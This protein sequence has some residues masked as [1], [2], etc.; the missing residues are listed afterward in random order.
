[1]FLVGP[2][3]NLDYFR[4]GLR[5]HWRYYAGLAGFVLGVVGFAL[6][7]VGLSYSWLLGVAGIVISVVLLGA[8]LNGRRGGQVVI[9]EKDEFR[10]GNLDIGRGEIIRHPVLRR[11]RLVVDPEVDRSLLYTRAKFTWRRAPTPIPRD[12]GKYAYDILRHRARSKHTV[13][14]GR[15]VRQ[16]TDL[17]PD[18]LGSDGVIQLSRTDY[19]SLLC[20]NYMTEWT[21]CERSTGRKIVDGMSL[22]ADHS[23]RLRSLTDSR[24]ANVIGVST[25]GL[26]I[27]HQVVLIWQDPQAQ[28]S[29]GHYAP[30]GSGS[31]DF[32]DKRWADQNGVRELKSLIE[33]AMRR[34]LTEEARVEPRDLG[35]TEV[36]GYYRWLNKGAKPEYS[37]ITTLRLHSNDFKERRVRWVEVNYVRRIDVCPVD[38]R[39]LRADPESMACLPSEYRQKCSVP[40]FMCLRSLGHCLQDPGPMGQRLS[41]MVGIEPCREI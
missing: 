1:M 26:T 21:I 13:F 12:T 36:L 18:V 3:S 15:L 35:D 22:I 29:A 40:L 10:V 6:T 27:D 34:E 28:S 16:D 14:N 41:R 9:A 4:T 20:S 19:Y 24:L 7:P 25:L 11:N 30:A 33:R 17:D 37:G 5:G 38:F 32:H 39:A 2:R 23:K 31:M 8:E